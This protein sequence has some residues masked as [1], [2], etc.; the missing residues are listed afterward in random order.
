MFSNRT[1]TEVLVMVTVFLC[2]VVP[3]LLWTFYSVKA[4][5][6]VEF[7]GSLT[8][9]MAAANTITLGLLGLQQFTAKTT[10]TTTDAAGVVTTQTVAEKPQ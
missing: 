10:T 5:H 8:G 3:S 1:F 9:F 6:L 4:G 7:P 2:I